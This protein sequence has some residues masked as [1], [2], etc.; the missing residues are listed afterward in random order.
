MSE[1]DNLHLPSGVK[2]YLNQ[3]APGLRVLKLCAI[4]SWAGLERKRG[5]GLYFDVVYMDNDFIVHFVG[6]RRF[7]LSTMKQASS[8]RL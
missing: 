3:K 8:G 6:D 2:A 4:G 7:K 5:Y 1:K